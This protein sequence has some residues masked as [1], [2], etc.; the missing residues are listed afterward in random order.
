[1]DSGTPFS[2]DPTTFLRFLDG[3]PRLSPAQRDSLETP[4]SMPELVAAV[5]EAAPD[6]PPGLDGVLRVLPHHPSSAWP[7]PSYCPQCHAC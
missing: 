5:Q 6:K 1:V 4:F 2:P 3:L 7:S